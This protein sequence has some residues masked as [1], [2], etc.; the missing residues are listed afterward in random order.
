MVNLV[1]RSNGDPDVLARAV[2]TA[3]REVDAAA[4][5]SGVQPMQTVIDRTIAQP[6]LLAWMFSAFAVLALVVAGVG[7]YAITSYAV[8]SRTGEFGLRMALGAR[9][10]DVLGL[11]MT[12]GLPTVL[13][14]VVT[15]VGGAVLAARLV[16]GLLYGIEPLD[17]IS[18]ATAAA[19]IAG[20]AILAM[21]LPACR[22]ARVDP[23]TALRD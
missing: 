5:V 9:P 22:A 8:S 3:V 4:A 18:L 11:V 17:V 19:V 6:R 13:A 16:Q 23:L 1:V 7:V 21:I 12:G 14:G 2:S 20:T 10:L 15:G